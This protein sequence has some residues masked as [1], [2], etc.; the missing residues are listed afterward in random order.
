MMGGGSDGSSSYTHERDK[1]TSVI[2]PALMHWVPSEFQNETCL[3]DSRTKMGNLLGSPRV[4][5]HLFEIFPTYVINTFNEITSFILLIL[6]NRECGY[7]RAS[8]GNGAKY[9]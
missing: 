9:N 3:G 4:V 7:F 8:G 1:Y 6:G 5:H 2:I